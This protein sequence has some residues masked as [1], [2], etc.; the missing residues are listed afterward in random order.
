MTKP[1]S[2]KGNA[3][4]VTCDQLSRVI[5]KILKRWRAGEHPSKSTLLNDL[6]VVIRPG[7]N[8]GSLRALE[9]KPAVRV[10]DSNAELIPRP[11]KAAV[12]MTA[13]LTPVAH[14]DDGFTLAELT[15]NV[16][17]LFSMSHH[18]API[19]GLD[20]RL[21]DGNGFISAE[22]YCN[23]ILLEDGKARS[24]RVFAG[25]IEAEV[26]ALV[27]GAIQDVQSTNLYPVLTQVGHGDL[28]ILLGPC[29]SVGAFPDVYRPGR[30]VDH[31]GL[32]ILFDEEIPPEAADLDV[33]MRL[34][35][36][37]LP[38][39]SLSQFP[40]D[41]EVQF[42][43]DHPPMNV[44]LAS[45]FEVPEQLD[46]RPMFMLTGTKKWVRES[47][48]R[49]SARIHGCSKLGEALDLALMLMKIDDPDIY[50]RVFVS[51]E[52]ELHNQVALDRPGWRGGFHRD[53]QV[54]RVRPGSPIQILNLDPESR[55]RLEVGLNGWALRDGFKVLDDMLAVKAE[56][57][58]PRMQRRATH[59]L[60]QV[61][62]IMNG[63][64]PMDRELMD[65]LQG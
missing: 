25:G 1:N 16:R 9:E 60:A 12:K 36:A 4:S 44:W 35:S 18:D 13:R 32:K 47:D 57:L 2:H 17:P 52:P 58:I 27:F 53:W 62:A 7:S 14:D 3:L 55:S 38:H 29:Q 34:A 26:A 10:P 49:F 59:H 45:E 50:M 46:D 8:W 30:S 48:M 24:I 42:K 19:I 51:S 54:L 37:A 22:T 31:L 5:D 56:A 33:L 65:K 23:L 61:E 6:A 21:T 43:A 15:E 39:L 11:S 41:E 64:N 63:A 40:K 28:R 20:L